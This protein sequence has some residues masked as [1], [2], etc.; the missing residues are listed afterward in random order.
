MCFQ[1]RAMKRLNIA[2]HRI[3]ANA[4]NIILKIAVYTEAL[5]LLCVPGGFFLSIIYIFFVFIW[6]FPFVRILINL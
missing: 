2:E 5:I 6:A 1:I 4:Y 3:L